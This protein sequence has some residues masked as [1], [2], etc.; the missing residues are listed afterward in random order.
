MK[1]LR[2]AA[3]LVL[4]FLTSLPAV[5]VAPPRLIVE[6][7]SGL[8]PTARR[9]RAFP[10]AE[11]ESAM[12][13]VGL[14]EPGPPIRVILA[15]EGSGTALAVPPWVSGYAYSDRGIVVLIPS[16][17]PAY[18]DASLEDLL[19]HEVAHVLIARASGNQPLPRWFHEGMAMIAGLTWGLD[20]R[21]RL[22]MTLLAD[23][24][25][26]LSELNQRFQGTGAEVYRA[27]AIS[28][29][30]VRDLLE[31]HGPDAPARVLAGV[32]QGLSFEDAFLR[33]TGETLGEAESSFWDDQSFW[34][35]WIPILTSSAL[36]WIAITLLFL[37]A[38]KRRR[39][40]DAALK[41]L[42]EEEE[43]RQRLAAEARIVGAGEELVN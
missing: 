1:V 36:L 42:W 20:D 6:A 5:S 17:T 10:P 18:P 7:P 13:L 8:E 29:S 23:R 32:R 16:R 19:R 37:W 15:E 21:A 40:R 9:V 14:A 11:L 24:E 25:I 2:R 38:V 41:R 33:A 27:Y 26:S 28:G 4:L 22:T 31:R 39:T 35:R 34:Y 12:R 3:L 30:F 43:E